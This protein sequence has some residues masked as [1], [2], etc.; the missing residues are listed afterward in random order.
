MER[1]THERAF[2]A[3]AKLVKGEARMSIP[4]QLDDDDMVLFNYITDQQRADGRRKAKPT[5][6]RTFA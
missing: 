6:P 3:L 5:L 1:V 2:A 4:P